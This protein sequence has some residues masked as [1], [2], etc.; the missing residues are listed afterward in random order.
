MNPHTHTH[1]YRSIG[2]QIESCDCGS[3][4]VVVDE[5]TQARRDAATIAYKRRYN[6]ALAR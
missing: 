4:R 3:S 1:T 6:A 2:N 5:A